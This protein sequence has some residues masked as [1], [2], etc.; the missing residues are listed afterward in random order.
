M[1]AIPNK[2]RFRIG[3]VIIALIAV[4]IFIGICNASDRERVR[5]QIAEVAEINGLQDV[6]VTLKNGSSVG[7]YEA[8][9]NCS[10]FGEFTPK[11]MLE[12]YKAI[13]SSQETNTY[14]TIGKVI[15]GEDQ[16]VIYPYSDSV[17]K[18]HKEIYDGQQTPKVSKRSTEIKRVNKTPAMTEE[19]ANALRGTG[20][21]G[22][23]PGSSAEDTELG[24]AMNKCRKCG[25]HTTNGRYSLCDECLY[26]KNHGLD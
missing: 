17:Y 6:N 7:Q 10:N 2:K 23:R 5:D 21:H 26:N 3:A 9:I 13:K 4:F 14:I 18:N 25:M 1:K 24:A 8:N 22:T 16:Y 15:S 11:E 12:I 19:E 20:Y